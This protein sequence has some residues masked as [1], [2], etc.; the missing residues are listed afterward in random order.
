MAHFKIVWR[1][2]IVLNVLPIL[3]THFHKKMINISAC[4]SLIKTSDKLQM[5]SMCPETLSA[6]VCDALQSGTHIST[7]LKIH[8]PPL[9][10]LRRYTYTTLHDVISQKTTFTGTT[11][12]SS[13]LTNQSALTI[14]TLLTLGIISH[15]VNGCLLTANTI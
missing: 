4:T 5:I 15:S 9:P 1:H 3:S 10:P 14:K 12:R 8:I 11:E 2:T 13:D 6:S 7:F